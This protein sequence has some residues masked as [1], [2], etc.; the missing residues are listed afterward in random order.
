M[1]DR[2]YRNTGLVPPPNTDGAFES[3]ADVIRREI[4]ESDPIPPAKRDAARLLAENVEPEKIVSMILL[5]NTGLRQT[6]AVT[7]VNQSAGTHIDPA[8]FKFKIGAADMALG[9]APTVERKDPRLERLLAAQKDASR[10][11]A[12]TD[13]A[14]D[15]IINIVGLRNNISRH[16]AQRIVS[17]L[18]SK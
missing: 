15:Q 8:K 4:A 5:R 6:D 3:A 2:N 18:V 1:T 16:D 7:I 12:E 9:H 10:I 13:M 17:E 11:L 14:H